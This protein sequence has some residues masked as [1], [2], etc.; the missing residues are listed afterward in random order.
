M[1]E[2][3]IDSNPRFDHAKQCTTISNS[4]LTSIIKQLENK[5]RSR[6]F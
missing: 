2:K 6:T 5:V 3:F 4:T 1:N